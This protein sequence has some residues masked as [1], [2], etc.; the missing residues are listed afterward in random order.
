[1]G[2][3]GGARAGWDT[4]MRL[5]GRTRSDHVGDTGLA[6]FERMAKEGLMPDV[7]VPR[8]LIERFRSKNKFVFVEKGWRKE[9][10]EGRN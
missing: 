4:A 5:A 10:K 7:F 1:M 9:S 3:L 6:G 8:A 2:V